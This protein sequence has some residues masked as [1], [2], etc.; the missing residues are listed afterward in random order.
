MRSGTAFLSS[1]LFFDTGGVAALVCSRFHAS[2]SL[3]RNAR[4]H[5][6]L[7]L[8]MQVAGL[9]R[10]VVTGMGVVSCLGNTLE[11]VAESLFRGRSGIKHSQTYENRGI[12]SH[13]WGKPDLTEDEIRR[14]IPSQYL[15]YCSD[16][17]KYAYMSMADAIKD[18]RLS[19][20]DYECNPRVACV[21]G[22]GGVSL[23]DVVEATAAVKHAG[24]LRD[25]RGGWAMAVGP[26]RFLRT[27]NSNVCAVLTNS[28]QLRGPSFS[29]AAA[30]STGGH[31]VG[32][33][34][35]QI[36]LDK[37]DMA[38]CG[39]GD[40]AFC[41][42]FAAMCDAMGVL[43]T[44]RNDDPG[45]ASRPFD[46]NRD[47]LVLG[48]GGGVVVLEELERAMRRGA[49]IHAE[50]T[51]YAA[52]SDGYDM[53]TP[54]G[55]GGERCMRLAINEANSV[56]GEIPIEYIN[57]H[58]TSTIAGD[59]REI[60]AI[61]AVFSS[62]QPF[63]GST[64]SLTGHGIGAAGV[65]ESIYT[66]LMMKNKFMAESKNIDTVLDEGKGMNILTHRRDEPFRRA[67]SNS[68]G[69]GGTNSVLIFDGYN[70]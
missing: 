52:N 6:A 66:L 60:N 8:T 55:E 2:R 24:G 7:S 11:D 65:Q 54:S 28:F 25:G 19:P 18:A 21:V 4:G 48:G 49:Q 30:C 9:R 56:S 58:A 38:F 44:A 37:A 35:Q 47:G 22:Q 45:S 27:M 69:F 5:K 14:V 62:S 68:F 41:W 32:M 12:R 61:K 36:M 34:R 39:A 26:N 57:A 59:K 64:K 31:S 1:V 17:A 51:G 16:A 42:P 20:G 46:A 63:I 43:S 53:V 10:V 40:D 15:P 70:A 33:G 13:L 23:G 67:L 50:V 3:R 29:I